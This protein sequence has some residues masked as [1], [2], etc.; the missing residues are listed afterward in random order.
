MPTASSVLA[1]R[2]WPAVPE[3]VWHGVSEEFTLPTAPD[4]EAHFQSLGDP[5]AIRRA[6]QGR[7]VHCAS[8]AS[9]VLGRGIPFELGDTQP[10][11]HDEKDK[12]VYCQSGQHEREDRVQNTQ[13]TKSWTQ[14]QWFPPIVMSPR[15]R[16]RMQFSGQV[17]A[18][19]WVA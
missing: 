11:E 12:G 17:D 7:S 18:V 3:P 9:A 4:L 10:E 8:G 13:N 14:I 2:F 19:L 16:G 6:V 5:E 15:L 1:E